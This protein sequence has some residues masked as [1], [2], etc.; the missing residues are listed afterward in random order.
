MCPWRCRPCWRLPDALR[1]PDSRT[2]WPNWPRWI[3]CAAPSRTMPSTSLICGCRS[4]EIGRDSMHH[5]RWA[6][7]CMR[8]AKSD[9]YHFLN[10][11]LSP[12][13]SSR[14]CWMMIPLN[15]LIVPHFWCHLIVTSWRMCSW[16]AMKWSTSKIFW[17]HPIS[18]N[19]IGFNRTSL[20]R[21]HWA[22]CKNYTE[23]FM[24]F[25]WSSNINQ[26]RSYQLKYHQGCWE[27]NNGRTSVVPQFT[28]WIDLYL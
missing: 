23:Y 5:W 2:V 4:C 8:P 7:N 14:I 6:W 15:V 21:N 18:M 24:E 17:V 9:V 28:S 19:P 11:G 10:Q 12:G 27:I 13:S 20:W 22:F 1:C 25:F 26:Q 16:D 3:N